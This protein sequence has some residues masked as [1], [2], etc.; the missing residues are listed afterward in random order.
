MKTLVRA[1][2]LTFAVVR[3]AAA[4]TSSLFA[5]L[6]GD[7]RPIDDAA[8]GTVGAPRWVGNK[9][10]RLGQDFYRGAD[11]CT[12]LNMIFSIRI[13][14]KLLRRPAIPCK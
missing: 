14:K 6:I 8:V 12:T 10:D 3:L 2:A 5:S 7:I 4:P 1:V 13:T 9:S 11:D